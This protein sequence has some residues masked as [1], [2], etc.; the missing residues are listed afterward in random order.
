VRIN[1]VNRYPVDSATAHHTGVDG[2]VLM[3]TASGAF[4]RPG[5]LLSIWPSFADRSQ[6]VSPACNQIGANDKFKQTII[7]LLFASFWDA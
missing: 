3:R 5:E 2:T 1:D 7:V 6:R 4:S